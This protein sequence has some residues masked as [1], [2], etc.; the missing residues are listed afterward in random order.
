MG[1]C[2][3]I[4]QEQRCLRALIVTALLRSDPRQQFPSVS[5]LANTPL[6]IGLCSF[7]PEFGL[8]VSAGVTRRLSGPLAVGVPL[9]HQATNKG[10]FFF[11]SSS[12]FCQQRSCNRAQ[13]GGHY[14]SEKGAWRTFKMSYSP[15]R[16]R[17]LKSYKCNAG[18]SILGEGTSLAL[19]PSTRLSW[20]GSSALEGIKEPM[21]L[22]TV[23]TDLN[24]PLQTHLLCIKMDST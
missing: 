17:I 4:P 10:T 2:N 19:H 18:C 15:D 24:K 22:A 9:H 12:V 8:R 23:V 11:C 6:R 21:W 7:V 3:L 14:S 13:S 16:H 1:Y 20:W 5:L